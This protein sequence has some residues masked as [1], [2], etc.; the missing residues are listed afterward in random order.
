MTVFKYLHCPNIILYNLILCVLERLYN[1]AGSSCARRPRTISRSRKLERRYAISRGIRVTEDR[2]C[3]RSEGCD[4]AAAIVLIV[5]QSAADRIKTTRKGPGGV[6]TRLPA[7]VYVASCHSTRAPIGYYVRRLAARVTVSQQI[8][9][10]SSRNGELCARAIIHTR[11][12]CVM[13]VRRDGPSHEEGPVSR[14]TR[15]T[16]VGSAYLYSSRLIRELQSGKV[17][18]FIYRL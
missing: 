8:T 18:I 10:A 1:Y 4:S 15:L 7:R 14:E 2:K 17:S 6:A 13:L 3:A 5:V 16:R 12:V 9:R 11:V